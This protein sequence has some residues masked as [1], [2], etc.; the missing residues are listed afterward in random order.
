MC[1]STHT[2]AILSTVFF[3]KSSTVLPAGAA[4]VLFRAQ[5]GFAEVGPAVYTPSCSCK[6]GKVFC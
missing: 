4:D 5:Q 6:H 3:A 1:F 2:G